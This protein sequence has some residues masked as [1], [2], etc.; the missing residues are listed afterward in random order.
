MK[1]KYE[2][3]QNG[4]PE[5]NNNPQIVSLN[6]NKPHNDFVSYETKEQAIEG[7]KENSSRYISLNGKW[8]FNFCKDIKSIPED[9]YEI[10]YNND[11]WDEIDVPSNWQIKGYGIPQYTNLIYPWTGREDIKPP[12]APVKINEAGCYVKY[13]DITKEQLNKK[14]L[15]N[16][17]GVESCFYLYVNGE[18]VGFSKDSFSPSEFDITDYLVEGKNKI[19][20]KVYRWCDASWL[21]DQDF[22][23]LSGIFR[24]VYLEIKNKTHIVDFRVDSNLTDD[25]KDGTF[26][27]KVKVVGIGN[28][29]IKLELYDKENIIYSS[30]KEVIV[31]G[32]ANL[33][34]Q[35]IIDN[36]RKWSAEQPNLYKVIICLENEN[37]EVTEYVSCD[38]GFRRF[39]IKENVM[40]INGKRILFNGVNRH[41]FDSEMGRAINKEVMEKDIKIMKQFNVN[42]LRTS[43]YPNN[44]YM[45]DLCD[46]YGLYVIDEV[47]LE[48]HGTWKY[49][50]KEEE[51]ALPGSKSEWTDAVLARCKSMFERDKNHPS[52]IIWSLGNESFGG[53]NFRKMYRFFKD[54]DKSRIVH[55]EGI[56]HHRMYEDVSEIESQMYTRPWEIEEYAKNNPKKPHIMCEYTHSMGNSNGNLDAYYKLFRKYDVLQGGFVWD[57]KDQA[58]LKKEG[59]I[60]YL[61]YGGDFGDFPNDYDF[62]GNGLVFA[63]GEVTPKFYEIK[64]WYAD[65]LFE[66][67]KEGLVKIK[68]DY[69]FNNL[70]RYDIFITTTKNGEFVDEKCVTIDLE[71]G[72]TYELEYDVVQKR[73]KGEEYI[74]TFTVKEKN[75]TMYAP[76]GHEI[77]HH[78]VVLKPNTLKIE[79]EENTNKVNINEE[80]K[81]ITLSTEKVKVSLSKESGLL[82]QYIVNGENILKEESRPYFWR[83][84]TNNDRG[85]KNEV[86]AVTWRNPNMNLVNIKIENYINLVN[87]VVDIELDNNSTVTYVYSLDSNSKLKVQQILNPNRD[88]AKIPAISDMF[89]LKEEFKNITYYGRGEIEN[90]WDKYKSAKVG[91]Y[92]DIVT[93]KMVNYLQPQENGAKTDVRYLEI[94]N[95]KGEGI[96]I[97]GVPTFEFNISKYHPEDVE[98]A[99]HFYKLKPLDATVL[100]IIYKQMGVGGDDSWRALPHPEYILNPN[101]IYTLTYEIKPI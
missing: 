49:G 62:S 21:E 80:D 85:F 89:I 8:K 61:A 59:D 82:A 27:T 101:K 36:P 76:K 43:H 31:E 97:S 93:E 52:I 13:I 81:L 40:Y 18:I 20:V 63:N 30:K 10:N 72:Q 78:Q 32:E 16:F 64:Y 66:D 75:E 48:T 45:Y 38:T 99:D 25:Y 60:S 79:R 53:E 46:K 94:K 19:G 92:E 37:N 70:N 95:E 12:F 50:Q 23:R 7:I 83:A 65:V 11:S 69:L 98:I 51:G 42:A 17:Q 35:T 73:Y 1:F 90:Y 54:N 87:L 24:D 58:I 9:F 14:V 15:I 39:E 96:K 86:D 4:Y 84:S 34:F 68:N 71:P 91:L 77:K 44:P 5:W 28:Y 74:V 6:M 22:W 47:N 41:E 2:K 29:N 55:Y 26:S 3:P 88:L 56:F 67:V 33:H 100:R 57:F